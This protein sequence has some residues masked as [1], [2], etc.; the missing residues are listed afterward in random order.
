[1]K[2]SDYYFMLK[3]LAF[4]FLFFPLTRLLFFVFNLDYFNNC[5]YIEILTAFLYGLR[6]DFSTLLIVNAFYI[7]FSV[8]PFRK[9]WYRFFLKIV[10][11][12]S[13]MFFL[14]VN[15]VDV[16]FFKF[17][18]KK[19]QQIYLRCLQISVIKL[20]NSLVTIGTL[21][22][23]FWRSGTFYFTILQSTKKGLWRKIYLLLKRCLL[24]SSLS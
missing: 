23:L 4:A 5:D 9:R 21:P 16:E 2:K 19:S 11:T 3:S 22:L 14:G 15:V 20:S 7:I 24:A 10:Y 13:N 8:I 1:M 12:V 17:I 6:F 18:G